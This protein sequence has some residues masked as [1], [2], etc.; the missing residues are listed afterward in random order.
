MLVSLKQTVEQYGLLAQ[1]SLGQNF[2]LDMNIT[3]KIVRLSLEKQGLK[4]FSGHN[5]CEIGPGPGGLTRAVLEAEPK[6]LTVVEMDKRCV[7]I[8]N[9]LK[10]HYP[11][12]QNII[13]GDATKHNVAELISAPRQVVSNLPYNVSV[14]LLLGWLLDIKSYSALTLMFQKEV[15][16]RILAP[17]RCKDYGRISIL[18]QLSCKVE[19]LFDLPPE[20]FTPA[21]KIW[22]SVLLFQSREDAPTADVLKKIEKVTAAAFGQRRKML[23]QSLKNMPTVLEKCEQNDIPLTARAEELTPQEFLKISV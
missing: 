20:C 3:D 11:S 23:R 8:M 6:S 18:A 17:T 2:L 9:D 13:L 22:S 5:V 10:E 14:P 7:W 19:K 1:K 12:L 16:E 4:D 15:A 21:P